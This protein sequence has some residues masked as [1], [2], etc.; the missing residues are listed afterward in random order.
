MAAR[1]PGAAAALLTLEI[2]READVVVAR[3]RA[4]QLAGLLGLDR[5]DQTRLA[6]AVSELARNAYDYAGGGRVRFELESDG[7]GGARRQS[8][9]VRVSDSGPGIADLDAVLSGRYVSRTGMGVGLAGARRL[10]DRF[11]VESAVGAG[12][13]VEIARALPRAAPPVGPGEV[14]ALTEAL[15]LE[16]RDA[17]AAAVDEVQ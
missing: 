14:A 15:A 11:R 8:L 12:T 3:G 1:P 13:R 16:V 10:V 9:V 6:T 2:R 17:G 4:R 5:Q 7:E